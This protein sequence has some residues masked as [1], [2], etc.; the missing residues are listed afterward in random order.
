MSTPSLAPLP[1]LWISIE[2]TGTVIRLL[3]T[4]AGTGPTLK[5]ELPFPAA[6]SAL[7]ALLTALSAWHARPLH[8]AL[9]ADAVDVRRHPERWALLA[10]DLSPLELSVHWVHRP[11]PG[12]LKHR[13]RFLAE[14]G[15]T[16]S[17]RSLVGWAATG[18]P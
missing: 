1:P 6:P 17:G 14:M 10:G 9:D 5:A 18:L 7:P 15:S 4:E 3:L 12:Q 13:G 16:R 8:A 11:S 2:P